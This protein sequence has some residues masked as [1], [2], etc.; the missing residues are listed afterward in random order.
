MIIQK[1]TQCGKD[2]FTTEESFPICDNC[3]NN[4]IKNEKSVIEE[5]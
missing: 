2:I 5:V 4:E 1:C 3:F